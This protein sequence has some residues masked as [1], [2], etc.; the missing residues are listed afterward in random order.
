MTTPVCPYSFFQSAPASSDRT[1]RFLDRVDAH[2]PTLPDDDARRTFLDGQLE[3]WEYRYDRFIASDGGSGQFTDPTDPP[4][5]ADFLL[6]ILGLSNR[7]KLITDD[8]FHA[9][10]DRGRTAGE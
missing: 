10:Q 5:A 7:R 3:G 2:L 1:T 9:S 6:T 8:D 4:T